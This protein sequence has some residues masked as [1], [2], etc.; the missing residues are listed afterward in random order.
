MGRWEEYIKTKDGGNKKL[1]ELL[2]ENPNEYK[3]FQFS[4]L[5]ILPKAIAEEEVINIENRYKD[6]LL[7]R[8]EKFGLN[9]N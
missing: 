2:K 4:I 6:K 3:S 8:S 7:T 5:H 9:D 1:M